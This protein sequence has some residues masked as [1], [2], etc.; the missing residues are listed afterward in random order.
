M[1]TNHTPVQVVQSLYAA[2]GRGDIPA[3]LAQLDPNVEWRI[4]VEPTAPGV[5]KVPTFVQRRGTQ[6]AAEFFKVIDS[7]LEFHS[8]APVSFLAGEREVAVRIALDCTV[9]PTGIRVKA[10]SMHHWTLDEAGK[11]IRFI[12]FVDTLATAR[13][14]DVVRAKA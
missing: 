5:G 14:W 3:I 1:S 10:E 8:F 13:A 9:R 12:D 11:V 6:G 4:N 2:F 7:S